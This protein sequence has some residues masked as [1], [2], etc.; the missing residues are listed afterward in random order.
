M[1]KSKQITE[2]FYYQVINSIEDYAVFTTDLKRNINSWNSGAE[3]LLGYKEEEII[4]KSISIIFTP[5]DIK[6]KKYE[7]EFEDAMTKGKALDAKWHLKK[8]GAEFWASGLLFP[9]KDENDILI[10]FTKILRDLTQKKLF[11]D[12]LKIFIKRERISKNNIQ[13]EKER[14]ALAQKS[15]KIGTYEWWIYK[16]KI[17]W[18]IELEELYGLPK[19]GFKGKYENWAKK[20]HKDDIKNV[21]AEIQTAIGGGKPYDT[22]FRI[23]LPNGKE[24]WLLGKG[25]VIYDKNGK[26]ERMVGVNMDITDRKYSENNVHFLSDATKVLSSSLNYQKTL[27]MLS[28]IAVTHMADWCSIE[29]LLEDESLHLLALAHT[30]QKKLIWVKKYKAKNPIDMSLTIG[31]SNV[32]R[33]KK[34]ELYPILTDEVL[35]KIA[36]NPKELKLMKT[37][38]FLSLMIVPI[39]V[40]DK[41]LGIIQFVST[42]SERHYNKSDLAI[43]EEVANRAALAIINSELYE[44]AQKEIENRKKIEKELKKSQSQFQ[45]LYNAN[46]IG[47]VYADLKGNIFTANDAYLK[48]LGYSRDDLNS[49][50]I[51]W[52]KLTPLEY[53][54][55]DD[56]SIK[57]LMKK[58]ISTPYEK[59][60]IKKDGSQ[61]PVIIG[62]VLINKKTTEIIAFVLDITERKR[63][64]QRKDEFIGIASHELKTP[65]TSIKGYIQILERIIQQMGDEKL[66]LYLKKTNIYIEKLNS[67]ITDLLDVSKIQA[68]KLL[69]NFSTFNFNDLIDETIENMQNTNKIHKITRIGKA[70]HLIQADKHRIEQV[71]INFLTNAIKYSPRSDKVIVKIK[72]IEDNLQVSVQDFG[73]GIAQKSQDRL[74]QRFYRVES[75]A[76][77]FSG[78]GIGLY[79]SYEIIQRHHGKTWVKSDEGKGS[80]F[81]FSLPLKNKNT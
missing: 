73:I 41:A 68:G 2:D 49:N 67:L 1:N 45:A 32:L 63:L 7:K 34:A 37:I 12:E 47:V 24:K 66:K 56:H 9:L 17:V 31:V 70:N 62:S 36:N 75:S 5:I 77:K 23:I 72:N 6:E 33:T 38:G 39:I 81:Y 79:I 29:M 61:I 59:E 51:N 21:E 46:I 50:Q 78:L 14:L 30:D 71:L 76:R 11:D 22:E 54:K 53:Q 55:I 42:Q 52:K 58:G 13:R 15:A 57:E 69:L 60:Y 80:T 65:L 74:F 18:T 43:A 64:E 19:G 4:G 25:E 40:N 27:D 44:A 16:N 35:V 28:Q 20:V 10:G 8:G 26:A 48:I 3:R